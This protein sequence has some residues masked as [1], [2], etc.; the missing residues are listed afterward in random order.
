MTQ[1][2]T[3]AHAVAPQ[4]QVAIAQPQR[5]VGRDVIRDRERRRPGRIEHGGALRLHLDLAGR[6]LRIL[7]AWQAPLHRPLDAQHIFQPRL[8]GDGVRRRGL[9]RTLRVK[10]HLRQPIAIAQVDE[11]ELAVVAAAR[12]PAGEHDALADVGGGQLAA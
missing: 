11:D 12:D 4:V 7:L 2:D 1:H 5:L 6:E 8:A 3:L 9:R 10:D